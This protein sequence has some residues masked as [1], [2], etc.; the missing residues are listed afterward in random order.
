[1]NIATKFLVVLLYNKLVLQI[2]DKT[3]SIGLIFLGKLGDYVFNSKIISTAYV[4]FLLVFSFLFPLIAT[5]TPFE[6]TEY[7]VNFVFISIAFLV[8]LLVF[9][10]LYSN[11]SSAPFFKIIYSNSNKYDFFSIVFLSDL[12]SIKILMLFSLFFNTLYI[13]KS[14]VLNGLFENLFIFSFYFASYTLSN[15]CISFFKI[16]TYNTYK[17]NKIYIVIGNGIFVFIITF[18]NSI[19]KYTNIIFISLSQIFK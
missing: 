11:E 19:L 12:F 18:G 7:G 14:I 3:K 10:M 8:N 15:I 13:N 5:S 6:K 17:F 1:L 16:L 4:I 9:E 2:Q